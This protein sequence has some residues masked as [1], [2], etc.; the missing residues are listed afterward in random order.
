IHVPMKKNSQMLRPIKDK[1]GLKV[2]G[3]YRIPCECGKVYIGETG[4]SIEARCTEHKRHI[5]LVQPEKSAM[6]EHKFET[7]HN[8]DF[9]NTTVLEKTTGYM[10]R[11]IKEAVEIKLHPNNFNREEE[12]ETGSSQNT[13]NIYR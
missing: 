9:V 13:H 10:D 1:L 8:I 7:G 4:R 2:A 6:A 12:R 11:K 3:V 5:R